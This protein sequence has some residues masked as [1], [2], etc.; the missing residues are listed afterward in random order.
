MKA[1]QLEKAKALHSS[2]TVTFE[3]EVV[4]FQAYLQAELVPGRFLL[5]A[6][7]GR[8]EGRNVPD[9]LQNVTEV[10]LEQVG[11]LHCPAAPVFFCFMHPCV[12][13]MGTK[14]ALQL[15]PPTARINETSLLNRVAPIHI[16]STR[17]PQ[18]SM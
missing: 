18:R 6:E 1:A 3:V 14:L 15:C 17:H 7:R 12:S 9:S 2:S 13:R 10:T 4:H 8:V 11:A 16:G 5:A